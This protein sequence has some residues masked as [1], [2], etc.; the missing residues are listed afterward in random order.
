MPLLAIQLFGPP[1]LML[2]G[3]PVSIGRRKSRALLYYLAA[4]PTPVTRDH[5]LTRFWPDHDRAAAQNRLRTNLHGLRAALGSALQGGDETLALAPDVL[6]DVRQFAIGLASPFNDPDHLG[7]L[8]ELYRGEFLAGFT[9]PD[10]PS[11]DDWVAAERAHYQRLLIRG[12]T[13]LCRLHERDQHLGAALAALDRALALDPLQED[14]QRAAIRLSYLAGDRAGAIRRYDQL[15]H[16]LDDELG[17]PPMDETRGLYDAIITDTLPRD[18]ISPPV[19]GERL[20]PATRTTATVPAQPAVAPRGGLLPFSGRINELSRL[21]TLLTE[22]QLVVIEGEPGIGKTRLL[23]E[24][25]RTTGARILRGAAHE[26]ERA[27]PY[28]PIIEALRDLTLHADWETV[29]ATLTLPA[30]WLT[31]IARL[32]PELAEATDYPT[33]PPPPA[34]EAR[35]WEGVHSFLSALARQQ[36]LVLLL[37]DLHWADESTLALVGYLVRRS[38]ATRTPIYYLAATRV[39]APHTPHGRLLQTLTREGR[40]VQIALERLDAEAVSD[41]ARQLSPTAAHALADWLMTTSEGNPYM[42]VELLREARVRGL[43]DTI[44]TLLSPALTEPLIPKTVY[45][46]I[47]SRLVRLSEPARHILDAAV[48]VGRIFAFDVVVQAS[49]LSESAALD[50]IDELLAAGLITPHQ[51]GQFAFDHSLTMEVA[52]REVGELRHRRLHRRVG[53]ALEN[54]YRERLDDVAGL[55]AQH[56]TDGGLPE[57]AAPYAFR[58]GREAA[59]LAAWREAI[60]FYE[61]ALKHA[62][63]TLRCDI[64]MGMGHARYAA[65][66]A[67]EAAVIYEE[68]AILAK[69]QG[70]LAL[71]DDARL[72]QG[73]TLLPQARYADA[74]AI[75]QAVRAADRDA[76]QARAELLWGTALALEGLDLTAAVEHLG[77]AEALL[78]R[79]AAPDLDSRALTTFTLGVVA[80]QQGDLARAVAYFREVL[81]LTEGLPF[82][83]AD[84]WAVLTQNNLAYHLHLM[85][86]SSARAHAEAGFELARE[87]GILGF[88]TYL[89]STAGEIALAAGDLDTAEQHFTAGLELAE[90]RNQA[91][92]IAGLTANLGRVAAQRGDTVRA[93][94]TFMSAREQ[95][96]TVAAH[97]LVA[98]IRLWLAPLLPAS[99][100]R[101]E[102]AAVRTF[103]EQTGRGTLLDE[104]AQVAARLTLE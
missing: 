53:E 45:A 78:I 14:L 5:L 9:L 8:L 35:L 85:G 24:F 29:R 66:D 42:L 55:L 75:A 104:V 69:T 63:E 103:A 64:L 36:P 1:Q 90:Q 101:Q 91:E 13:A 94:H 82:D 33:I 67:A 2:D 68:A 72:L 32:L 71:A 70:N 52:E 31:E 58:A 23:E 27:L 80:A 6:V 81:T 46:L 87:R 28:Q 39:L 18:H 50:A 4:Q 56:F 95:A 62:D 102:L 20:A 99:E 3:H 92:R 38:M 40:V 12:L 76:S 98:Q 47:Q 15:R 100:A 54:L 74:V 84:Q 26:F 59:R 16:L 41:L 93:L 44:G 11:F 89:H 43:L 21:H 37:D 96:E 19:V 30:I 48:V 49:A 61:Q 25:A 34:D 73:R 83:T 57:R 88:Q 17:V 97:H 65:G 22:P 10:I 77:H 51:D 79:A 60:V 86:D 7:R